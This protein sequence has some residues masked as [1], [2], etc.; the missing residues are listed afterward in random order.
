MSRSGFSS[1]FMVK[2]IAILTIIILLVS[3]TMIYLFLPRDVGATFSDTWNTS[4]D[5]TTTEPEPDDGSLYIVDNETI[6][7]DDGDETLDPD[8]LPLQND[9]TTT[10]TTFSME[11][12]V[13]VYTIL[14]KKAVWYPGIGFKMKNA[15]LIPLCSEFENDIIKIEKVKTASFNIQAFLEAGSEVENVYLSAL[16]CIKPKILQMPNDTVKFKLY[17][18]TH[19][20][21]PAGKEYNKIFNISIK[22]RLADDPPGQWREH[23]FPSQLYIHISWKIDKQFERGFNG[24]SLYQW[25][26]DF[27]GDT[28]AFK[29]NQ[30]KLEN[31][32]KQYADIPPIYTYKP[33][34]IEIQLLKSSPKK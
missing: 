32:C 6:Y 13:E 9:T 33:A 15:S 4:E 16:I 17:P 23:I 18:D 30:E 25:C 22:Y 12:T 27:Y 24:Q 31:F 1:I 26:L 5:P 28:W 14:A 34:S 11:I 2:P 8:D 20:F 21:V 3:A 29:N 10:D 19:I 7:L